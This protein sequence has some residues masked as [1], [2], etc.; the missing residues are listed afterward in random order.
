LL[1]VRHE[2]PWLPSLRAPETENLLPSTMETRI[3]VRQQ[4]PAVSLR[5]P[6]LASPHT[7]R[8]LIPMWTAG[9]ADSI[10]EIKLADREET[11]VEAGAEGFTA[12]ELFYSLAT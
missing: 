11:S 6:A 12:A 2:H 7:T 8:E 9:V 5:H 1:V 3:R 10:C 4:Y